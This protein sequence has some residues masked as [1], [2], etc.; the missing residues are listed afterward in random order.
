MRW[1]WSRWRW[2]AVIVAV[3]VCAPA[4]TRALQTA[5]PAGAAAEQEVVIKREAVA[6]VDPKSYKLGLQLVPIKSLEL[7]AP[8]DGH[9]KSISAKL[10]AKILKDAEMVRMDEARSAIVLKRTKAELQAARIEKKRA[11]AKN[12]ADDVALADAKLEAAQADADLAQ[13][14][15]ERLIVRATFNGEVHAIYVTDGQYVRAGDR[16]ATLVDTSKFQL[17][18]PIERGKVAAGA[19]I[20]LKV[21]DAA[22]KAKVEAVVPPAKRF[23]S[24][25]DLSESLATAVV[26]IDNANGKLH[27]GQAVFTSLIP[28][29]PV[30]AVPTTAVT[31]Q[32]DGTRKVQVLRENIVRNITVSA[33]AR[34]GTERVYVTGP[35]AAGDEIVVSASKEL[36]DGTPVRPLVA[37]VESGA[38][39][40]TKTATPAASGAT[41]KAATGF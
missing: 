32:P 3:G 29:T 16:L 26:V 30:A 38:G 31:N 34:V 10:G 23:E 17:E 13:L 35:L 41:K 8:A 37:A 25:R 18:I 15:A 2:V 27:A 39:G 5:A 9:V 14:D 7:T 28:V 6:I 19:T 11:Q 36:A 1:V 22:V 21:E 40:A 12:D 20:D 33:L 4:V 24:L